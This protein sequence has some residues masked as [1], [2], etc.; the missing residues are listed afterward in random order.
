MRWMLD[1]NTCID[2]MKHHSAQVQAR[3]RRAAIGEVGIS[4]I[5]AL[6]DFL[7]SLEDLL[8]LQSNLLMS[9]EDL[10]SQKYDQLGPNNWEE[11]QRVQARDEAGDDWDF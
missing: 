9:F 7:A 4:A 6:V 10:M 3:L 8:R 2:A 5:A 1:T 11:Y